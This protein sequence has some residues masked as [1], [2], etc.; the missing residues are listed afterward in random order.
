MPSQARPEQASSPT[1]S[2][3]R[4][5]LARRFKHLGLLSRHPFAVPLIT[6]SFLLV[7]SGGIYL[8]ARSTDHLPPVNDANIVIVS[9]D[10]EQQI[11]PSKERTVGGLLAKLNVRLQEGDVVEPALSTTIN[12]D[13]FR[14]NVYRAL[15]VQIV[16]TSK[17]TFALSASKTPRAIARQTGTTVY[18][19]DIIKAEPVQDFVKTGAIGEQV[20]IDRATPINVD[21]YGTPVVLR[22]HATTVGEL[23]KEKKIKLIK[24]DQVIPAANTPI[25]PG[26]QVSFL[27]TGVKTE[28]VTEEIAMPVQK[29]ND[30]NLAYGTSAVRQQG[31]P[32]QQTVTYQIAITNNVETGRTAIQKVVTRQPVTQV[33]VVGTSL[34][35]IKGDMARAGIAPGDFQYADYI[36]GRES[37]WRPT[38]SN[39]SGAYGLCQALPGS[40]MAS[41]GSDWATN[42]VTQLRW[43]NGYAT[44]RYGSW[45]AAYSFWQTRH[46]W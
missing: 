19:E 29:I 16:D 44:G 14:I 27:R 7:I 40:K 41:A 42:P 10:G 37:G 21:L 18:P 36:I 15:P 38:A 31:A 33:E 4:A 1:P 8:V 43:C 11:V 17:R 5:R 2:K 12:Q 22:T 28:T 46:Y 9:D 45:A 6:F 32:G 3:R 13:Q 35:G 39:P 24:D 26:Q 23:I 30:A 34:S 25:T 20:I